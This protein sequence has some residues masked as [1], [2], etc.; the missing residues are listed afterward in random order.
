VVG[1]SPERS[2]PFH[3]HVLLW[4]NQVEVWFSILAEHAL[5]NLSLTR[6]KELREAIDRDVKVYNPKAAPFEW[7]K[8]VVHPIGLKSRYADLCN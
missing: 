8:A 1:S 3:P 2:L 5:K 7:T 4:L 6:A